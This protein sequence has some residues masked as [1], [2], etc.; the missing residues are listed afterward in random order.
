MQTLMASAS[1]VLIRRGVVLVFA[2]IVIVFL[3]GVIMEATGYAENVWKAIIDARVRAYTAALQQKAR[4]GMYCE[5]LG[6]PYNTEIQGSTLE[7]ST[8]NGLVVYSGTLTIPITED[9]QLN[10]TSSNYP[11]SL[12]KI[13]LVNPIVIIFN[14]TIESPIINIKIIRPDGIEVT[15]YN[16]TIP[17]KNINITQ[18]TG[19]L[20]LD[21]SIII[22]ADVNLLTKDLA[23]ELSEKYLGGEKVTISANEVN[24]Y[25]Y[26]IPSKNATKISLT[27]LHGD[28]KVIIQLIYN[29][30]VD[31]PVDLIAVKVEPP[32]KCQPTTQLIQEY[33]DRLYKFYQLDKPW[34][35]RVIPLVVNTLT[36]NLGETN[37]PSVTNVAGMQSPA[38][39][40][41]VILACLP[42]TVIMLTVAELVCMAIALPLAPKIAYHY[43]TKLDRLVVSYAALFNAIPVWWLG[44]VFIF[45]FSYQFHIFPATARPIIK[46]INTF[47]SDP[48]NSLINIA[49]Y[50]TL[51]IITIV[52]T[53][54]GG[55]F[56]SVRAVVL[57]VIREDFVTVAKAKGLPERLIVRKYIIRVA[58]P[59]IVTYIILALAGSL[60]GMII[61]ES[62]FDYPGMG[63]LYYAAIQAGDVPTILGL[64]YVLTGVYIA[65]RFFLEVLYIL[66]DPRVRL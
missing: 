3:T 15:M 40:S 42:R 53:F 48:I 34:Y 66:L 37:N 59:P 18:E 64:T 14:S 1:S 49:Y 29:K 58:A 7:L 16:N 19:T 41:A 2:L 54:L 24:K 31:L 27:P 43:G 35:V 63:S 46:Y 8:T 47:L 21:T 62:V 36:G 23:E 26:S 30:E 60:S 57:R 22:S 55:W 33:R 28:Y 13:V 5:S 52:I 39:V 11:P 6:V 45:I 65:A 20:K 61:T 51:P 9:S 50:V 17:T 44:L 4:G 10:Y 56:Y 38:P 12:P 25:L 32:T